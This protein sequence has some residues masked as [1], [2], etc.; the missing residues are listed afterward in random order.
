MTTGKEPTWADIPSDGELLIARAVLSRLHRAIPVTDSEVWGGL[1]EAKRM[2]TVSVHYLAN[3]RGHT[4]H[5]LRLWHE[6]LKQDDR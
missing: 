5:Y 6:M 3:H 2:L 4:R 1:V